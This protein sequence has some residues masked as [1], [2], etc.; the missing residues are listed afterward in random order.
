MDKRET[1]NTVDCSFSCW[2]PI[3]NG[4]Y[5]R[6]IL[7]LN[8]FH[9]ESQC[10]KPGRNGRS[11]RWNECGKNNRLNRLQTRHQLLPW[12][13]NTTINSVGHSFTSMRADLLTPVGMIL[14]LSALI[15]ENGIPYIVLAEDD[16]DDRD[17]FLAGMHKLYPQI[18]V[19]SFQ[20][21]DE[22][23]EFLETCSGTALPALMLI[24]YKMPRLT[25]PQVLKATGTGTRYAHVPKIVWSTSERQKDSDECLNLGAIRF[26]I[27][28]DTDYRLDELINSL[29]KWLNQRL[30]NTP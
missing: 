21:G 18:A 10:Q 3:S 23:L 25:A 19:R 15:M 20:D 4:G 6:W 11:A 17:L 26:V 2:K 22:L 24:D 12:R 14:S 9:L 1:E 8:V 7:S 30:I 13:K 28:P 16:P 29:G 5:H 27:K